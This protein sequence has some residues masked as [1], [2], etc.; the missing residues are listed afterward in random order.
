[1]NILQQSVTVRQP[2]PC[3]LLSFSVSSKSVADASSEASD[4]FIHGNSHR[5]RAVDGDLVVVALLPKAEW[6]S[7]SNA[8]AASAQDGKDSSSDD[9]G[10]K[11]VPT[12]KIVGILQ[13]N[14]RD[15]V[16]SFAQTEQVC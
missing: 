15:Y 1:M 3:V 2:L 8:I 11:A 13:R 4:I 9:S 5:N 14:W 12:G 16:A 6:K 10:G 7:P